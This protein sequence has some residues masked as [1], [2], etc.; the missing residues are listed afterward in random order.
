MHCL[1]KIG[2]FDTEGAQA[3]DPPE[4]LKAFMVMKRAL[5][6]VDGIEQE[7]VKG[8]EGMVEKTIK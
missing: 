8:T 1:D 5:I 3:L 6:N 4:V 2:I 7:Q